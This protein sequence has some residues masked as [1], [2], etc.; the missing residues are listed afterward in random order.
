MRPSSR[1]RSVGGRSTPGTT[2]ASIADLTNFLRTFSPQS[3]IAQ[4]IDSTPWKKE[5]ARA[6]SQLEAY[7][8][9]PWLSHGSSCRLERLLLVSYYLLHKL[10][11]D[12]RIEDDLAESLV[13]VELVPSAGRAN[14]LID[15]QRVVNSLTLSTERTSLRLSVLANKII[16]S[17]LILPIF[18]GDSGL[19][20][21]AICSEFEHFDKVVVV[22]LR[23]LLEPFRECR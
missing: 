2:T 6:A 14:Y 3:S 23:N 11:E 21:V 1:A 13:E 10:M 15:H 18:K 7:L 8:G 4:M 16:H 12:H 22:P 17:Y 20:S 19:E 9:R 5:L